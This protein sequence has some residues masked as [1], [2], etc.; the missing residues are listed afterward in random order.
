MLNYNYVFFNTN[1]SYDI[2]KNEQSYSSICVKDLTMCSDVKVVPFP[3]YDMSPWLVK[4]HGYHN[5][6]TLNKYIKLP[7]KHLWFP[8]YFRNQFDNE[9]PICF[10]VLRHLISIDYFKYLKRKYKACKIVLLNRDFIRVTYQTNPVLFHNPIFDLEMTIDQNEAKENG[11]LHFDEYESKIEV[12]IDPQFP[13][14]DVFF[15]GKAKDRL[16]NLLKAYKVFTDIGLK[17]CFYLTGVDAYDRVDLPGIEYSNR[18]LSY[19][20]MLS[21]TLNA[22]CILEI[23]QESAMGYTSRYLNAVMYGRKLITNNTSIKETTFY[24]TGYIQCVDRVED[25]DPK[26][27]IEGDPIVDYHYKGEYSPLRLIEQIDQYLSNN[28]TNI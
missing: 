3:L 18:N 6:K 28:C 2:D 14:C 9:K 19:F 23:N 21:R 15:A 11:M 10:V 12:P 7:F 4:L 17:C 8:Y 22:R 26:F 27:V 25:I 1:E 24:K 5:M 13:V 20:E 16:P